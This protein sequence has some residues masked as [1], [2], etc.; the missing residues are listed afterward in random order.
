MTDPFNPD[1]PF[2]PEYE[3]GGADPEPSSPDIM[4]DPTPVEVPDSGPMNL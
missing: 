3:P 1:Q 2:V 4:P